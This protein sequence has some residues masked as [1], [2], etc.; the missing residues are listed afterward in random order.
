MYIKRY[1]AGN[2]QKVWNE[3]EALKVDEFSEECLEDVTAVCK[4]AMRRVKLNVE[5]IIE[6]LKGLDY[7][8]SKFPDGDVHF[9]ESALEEVDQDVEQK[10]KHLE[11]I[12][13]PLPLTV[14]EFWKSI[15]SICL[16]GFKEAWPEFSDQLMV[17]SIDD[18]VETI[19]E[20][21][22][23][24]EDCDDHADDPYILFISPDDSQKDNCE[25][26]QYY[27]I[28]LPCNRVDGMIKDAPSETTFI[29]FLR[30]AFD[31][32]GFPGI[33]GELPKGLAELELLSI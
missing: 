26:G 11:S 8:F 2:E 14:K 31:A 23:F 12:A 1:L 25:G 21:Q 17:A 3:I 6:A 28:E 9:F 15:G 27:N 33:E 4:E 5:R 10:I 7:D 32:K 29:D 30:E 18:N 19:E 24:R 13:G 22:E 20:W 16:V